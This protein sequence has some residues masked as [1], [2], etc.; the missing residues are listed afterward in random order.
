MIFPR[1]SANNTREPA[2]KKPFQ[3]VSKPMSA[4]T[5]TNLAQAAEP[6]A[7]SNAAAVGKSA[8]KI[9]PYGAA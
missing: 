7:A 9:F 3:E 8:S 6:K 4:A 1:P 5:K 2:K